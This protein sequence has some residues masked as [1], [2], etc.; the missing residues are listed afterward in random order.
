MDALGITRMLE[1]HRAP[2]LTTQQM[3]ALLEMEPA[4]A[5]VRLHRLA[6]DGAIVR[7]MRGRYCLPSVHP[8]AVASGLYIPSYVSL[9]AAFEYHGTTTQSPRVIDVINTRRSGTVSVTLD[10]GTYDI[11]FVHLPPSLIYGLERV[12][13]GGKD[14]FVASRERAIVDGLMLPGNVPL[15]ETVACLR[16]GVDVG[17][18]VDYARRTGRQVVV[19]RLGHLLTSEGI[20]FDGAALG[21]ISSTYVPLDPSFP[22]RGVHD[23][24][25]RVIRNRVVE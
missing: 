16:S 18:M 2:V 10:A 4:S 17:R 24:H 9:L 25:W 3:S 7:V 13:V 22:R 6:R 1:E 5:T 12:R 14:A 21:E 11:T 8:L 15:D 23:P 20:E 19:K